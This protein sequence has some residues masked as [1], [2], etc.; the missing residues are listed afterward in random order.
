VLAYQARSVM[1]GNAGA[2][3][4]DRQD[5]PERVGDDVALAAGNLLAAVTA[6]TTDFGGFHRESAPGKPQS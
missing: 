5:Q 4:H 6:F 1:I 2:M 3:H